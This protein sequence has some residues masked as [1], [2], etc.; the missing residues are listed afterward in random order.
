MRRSLLLAMLATAWWYGPA[1]AQSDGNPTGID[2]LKRCNALKQVGAAGQEAGDVEVAQ[3][4]GY[5]LGYIVGYVS[6]FAARDAAG[7][8][9]RFCP[10]ANARIADFA[11]GIDQWLVDH[12]AGLEAMAPVVVLQAFRSRFPCTDEVKG[13]K[14]Q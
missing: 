6:G 14:T 4:Y 1:A 2:L 13:G 9:G 3:D 10:P 11:Q 5:C 7:E 8:A 12:P